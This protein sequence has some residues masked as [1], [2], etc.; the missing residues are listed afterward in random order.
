VQYGSLYFEYVMLLL[1]YGVMHRNAANELLVTTTETTYDENSKIISNLLCKSAGI[2]EYTR[3]QLLK[4]LP[5][6]AGIFAEFVDETYVALLS[7]S[8]AEA[9]QLAIKKAILKGTT[10]STIAKLCVDVANKCEMSAGI[11]RPF[12]TAYEYILQQ[13]E[14]YM[15]INGALFKAIA[16]KQTSIEWYKDRKPGMSIGVMKAAIDLL[17]EDLLKLKNMAALDKFVADVKQ[18]RK[19]I[20]SLLTA[21]TNDNNT[22]F[23][24]RVVDDKS[25][26]AL[27]EGK[28]IA[29]PVEYTPPQ[30]ITIQIVVKEGYAC[31]V[32]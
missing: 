3:G 23:F 11:I 28:C 5:K 10:G 20:D 4:W 17:P 13:F 26:T 30:P 27:P 1:A 7:L 6:P 29:K 25:A 18:E 9:Q 31:I 12:A 15:Y 19:E 2:F 32:Q 16:L 24:D 22:V 14:R 8:L 21:Y